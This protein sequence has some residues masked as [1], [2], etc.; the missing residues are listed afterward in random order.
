MSQQQAVEDGPAAAAAPDDDQAA[1]SDG[2]QAAQPTLADLY[3]ESKQQPKSL[4]QLPRL[5]LEAVRMVWAAAPRLLLISVAFKLVNAAALGGMLLLGRGLLDAVLQ[6]SRSGTVGAAEV[7]PRVAVLV[8]I[9]AVLGTLTA[10]GREIREVLSERAVRHAKERIIDA[11][12]A[13]GLEAYE[14]PAFHDRLVRAALAGRHRPMSLVE[15]LIGL[16]GSV[17]GIAGITAGLLVVQPWLAALLLLAAVPLMMSM[18]KAGQAMFG[19][20]VQM[21]AVTRQRDY[22]YDLLSEKESAKEVRAFNLEPFLRRRHGELYDRHMAE[23]RRTTRRRFR[24]SLLGSSGLVVIF[25]GCITLLLYLAVTGA[26]GLAAAA[27]AAG[28]ML[29][30]GERLLTTTS[31]AGSLYE[32]ALFLDDFNAFLRI[33]A[34]MRTAQEGLAPAPKAFERLRVDDV[35]FTY[36]SGRSPALRGA[37]M[38]I[39]AGEIVALVGENGSGKT[40]LAKLLSRLY[41]PQSG[42]ISWDGVDIATV[43]PDELRRNIAVIFQD[44]L[45]YALPARENVGM[46]DTGRITDLDA[47]VDAAGQADAHEFLRALPEGYETVLSPEFSGG[48]D[49]S[50]GQWQRVAL[51]R[52]FFRDAP[53]L[54]LDEPTAALDPRAEDLLFDSLRKLFRDRSVLLISHR[55]SSVRSADRIYVLADGQIVEHGNHE[56]LMALGGRYAELFTLQANPYTS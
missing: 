5:C 25:G 23:L 54:I 33:G 48:R 2:E 15:G 49:L 13:V 28:A 40:T 7:L 39:N 53:L 46:G 16:V 19:F 52:A 3:A 55:F 22:L 31:H 21:T 11:A 47:I 38:E 34:S 27:T 50:I 43:D 44:F 24:L 37:S 18:T 30:L 6:A 45:R 14:T 36:P 10:A 17:A 26:I 56:E 20:Q 4:R 41:L 42:T 8:G 1:T 29:L 9:L 35:E 32:S 12:T 51:A